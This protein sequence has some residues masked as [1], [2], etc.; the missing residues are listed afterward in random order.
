MIGCIDSKHVQSSDHKPT[1]CYKSCYSNS[2]SVSYSVSSADQPQL[3]I[4]AFVAHRV[5]SQQL[6]SFYIWKRRPASQEGLMGNQ[7]SGVKQSCCTCTMKVSK[8]STA[9]SVGHSLG[10]CIFFFFW[11]RALH[12]N[13][14]LAYSCAEPKG[15]RKIIPVSRSPPKAPQQADVYLPSRPLRTHCAGAWL[16]VKDPFNSTLQRKMLNKCYE[17]TSNGRALPS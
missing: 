6:V 16:E 11:S 3:I 9:L 17:N 1:V 14:S 15:C 5:F 13:S 8:R 12:L 4:T 7:S 2:L 10:G